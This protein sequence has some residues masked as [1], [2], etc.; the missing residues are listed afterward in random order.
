MLRSTLITV[1]ALSCGTTFA[2]T[3]NTALN[4]SFNH[5]LTLGASTW[6]RERSD[7]TEDSLLVGYRYSF[8][9]IKV[10]APFNALNFLNPRSS[11]AISREYVQWDSAYHEG[12]DSL[13]LIGGS[14]VTDNQFIF[15][16]L[17]LDSDVSAISVGKQFNGTQRISLQFATEVDLFGATY[18]EYLDFGDSSGLLYG[19]TLSS[20]FDD[21][22]GGVLD[23][24]YFFDR[25]WSVAGRYSHQ[26]Y[27]D[28]YTCF[29][30]DSRRTLSLKTNYW[31]N[32]QFGLSA[33]YRHGFDNVFNELGIEFAVRF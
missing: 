8:G 6:N 9:E 19:L 26:Q 12:D 7:V 4:Q 14:Y 18:R 27:L 3:Q 31:F 11:L 22:M 17:D 2:E 33:V 10:D 13:M 5:E 21:S 32:Q 1:I 25:Q 16:L 15:T 29:Q 28:D 20:D 23:L 24:E 30:C